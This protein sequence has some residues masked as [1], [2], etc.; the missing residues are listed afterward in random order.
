MNGRSRAA[1]FTVIEILVS[2][3]LL[4]VVVVSVLS[5]LPGLARANAATSDEQRATLVA[6]S[7]FEQAAA[8]Y[9]TPANYDSAAPLP[10]N[11]TGGLS[12]TAPLV[13]GMSADAAGQVNLKRVTLVCTLR[14]RT[15]TF[16]RDFVR[17]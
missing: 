9:A 2:I 16:E 1:G 12:C 10:E 7:Y 15:F 14:A 3:A 6:K 13:T 17:R 4:A 11:T 5:L 8:F